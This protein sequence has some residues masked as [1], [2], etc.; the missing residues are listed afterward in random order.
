MG[1]FV[2]RFL[3]DEV[4]DAVERLRVVADE[5]GLTMAQLALA[6]VL[7]TD[8]V[9]SAI[10]G[11]SRPGS[12]RTT[13][14]PPAA[15]STPRCWPPWTRPWPGCWSRSGMLAFIPAPPTN[16]FQLGPFFFHLYGL[17][18]ALGVLAAFWL[19]NRRWVQAGGKPGE[20]ERPAIWG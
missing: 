20:L 1:S 12:S 4:L 10:V 5:A 8:T 14:P 7:R 13:A 17:C 3:T 2:G 19:A 16:G 9:A 11:A 15:A 6:W 18:I